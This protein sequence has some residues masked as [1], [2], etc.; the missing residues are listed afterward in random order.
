MAPKTCNKCNKSNPPQ[1]KFCGS[2]GNTLQDEAPIATAD[3]EALFDAS[4]DESTAEDSGL[5]EQP[6][7]QVVT[8]NSNEKLNSI[9]ESADDNNIESIFDNYVADAPDNDEPLFPAKESV[10]N[11]NTREKEQQ[12]LVDDAFNA[13]LDK[14]NDEGDYNKN[15]DS[16]S[17]TAALLEEDILAQANEELD[18]EHH[19]LK[20]GENVSNKS[21]LN[22]SVLSE[23]SSKEEQTD[24]DYNEANSDNSDRADN[25]NHID[26]ALTDANE[27]EE[28]G[29]HETKS[30]RKKKTKSKKR[31]RSLPD[32]LARAKLLI[33]PTFLSKAAGLSAFTVLSLLLSFLIVPIIPIELPQMA[34]FVLPLILLFIV[35]VLKK[36]GKAKD[37]PFSIVNIVMLSAIFAITFKMKDK[38]KL[39]EQIDIGLLQAV[40]M[41]LAIMSAMY[42][43]IRSR[44]LHR[45]FRYVLL[46]IGVYSLSGLIKGIATGL[47]YQQT[48]T[49]RQ[50]SFQG[51]NN[52]LKELT[53][54]FEP[55]FIG[56]NLFLPLVIIIIVFETMRLIIN[57]FFKESLSGL[58]LLLFL[59][60]CL[61]V[62]IELYETNNVPNLKKMLMTKQVF[63]H[64]PSTS[65]EKVAP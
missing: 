57:K 45:V 39:P 65:A 6:L 48:I 38:L 32:A 35:Y 34:T 4:F 22:N 51:N 5:F 3:I 15:I 44:L 52:V 59:G 18:K 62:N 33:K 30:S 31:T 27:I 7:N 37:W 47:T 43:I 49:L 42:G 40:V 41:T 13:L 14:D 56:V 21:H 26:M 24:S 16:S 46:T 63:N 28:T 12:G 2:C 29:S 17:P 50:L 61:F 9:F 36:I 53:T 58:L 23:I 20:Q 8:K 1:A 19:P 54:L 10:N 55:T 25:T 60:G 11:G 64:T